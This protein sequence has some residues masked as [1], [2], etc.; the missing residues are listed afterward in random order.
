VWRQRSIENGLIAA[1]ISVAINSVLG[2][3]HTAHEEVQS[4]R[5]PIAVARV[6]D[7]EAP[8]RRRLAKDI[9]QIVAD[10]RFSDTVVCA[11]SH[12]AHLFATHVDAHRSVTQIT[13]Q[14]VFEASAAGVPAVVDRKG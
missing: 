9:K 13:E 3:R 6:S 11:S 14:I 5:R 10:A 7:Q 8:A 1:L 12:A 2:T 4:D